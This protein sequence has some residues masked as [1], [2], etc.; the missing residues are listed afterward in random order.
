MAITIFLGILFINL[1]LIGFQF[2]SR[3]EIPDV[4]V[5]PIVLP[6]EEDLEFQNHSSMSDH[7]VN[8]LLRQKKDELRSLFYET[9][10]YQ[11]SDLD[12]TRS[13][14]DNEKYYVFDE[15]FLRTLDD[16]VV[17]SLYQMFYEQL[18][19]LPTS[20][21]AH[22][23]YISDRDIFDSVHFDSVVAEVGILSSQMRL[24]LVTDEVIN[25][26]VTISA[27]ENIKDC[28]ANRIVPFELRK[29]NGVWKVS[30]F[31]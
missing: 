5:D 4:L 18:T 13:M 20:D 11:L 14:E 28:S 19:L 17:E 10:V 15:T 1:F 23:Y 6:D 2:Y 3:I 7:E 30:A 22:I 27:C 26:S 12:S 21:S 8:D 29:V 9:N 24:I 16:L 25:A 31:L